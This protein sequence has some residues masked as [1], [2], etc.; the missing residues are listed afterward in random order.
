MIASGRFEDA[1]IRQKPKFR[2]FGDVSARSEYKAGEPRPVVA[3]ETVPL[4]RIRPGVKRC[5][6]K[7]ILVD[8]R[9]RTV[10]ATVADLK[11]IGVRG[12]VTEG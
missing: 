7:T 6:C 12:V 3:T 11:E 2:M 9:Q 5:R 8:T 4:Q 10:V 1:T